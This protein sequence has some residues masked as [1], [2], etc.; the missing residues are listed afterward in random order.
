MY[1]ELTIR[2]LRICLVS[3]DL[4]S[5]CFIILNSHLCCVVLLSFSGQLDT[6]YSRLRGK[7]WWTVVVLAVELVFIIN[8]FRR[9]SPLW[10]APSLD[11]LYKKANERA[12]KHSSSMVFASCLSPPWV[13]SPSCLH[14]GHLPGNV[15]WNKFFFFPISIAF[16]QN[17]LSQQK[18]GNRIGILFFFHRH[19]RHVMLVSVTAILL[20]R[21]TITKSILIKESISLGACLPR[22]SPLA[23]LQA[24]TV[25]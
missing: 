8:W 7:L 22:F 1:F 2:G 11:G 23:S 13:P 18:N 5:L 14:D 9:D 20:S 16:G 17:H 4:V 6:V 15:R 10:A 21:D 12:S 24:D 3:G 19:L 25:L